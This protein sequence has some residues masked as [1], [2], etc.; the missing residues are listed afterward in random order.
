M[1]NIRGYDFD[2]QNNKDHANSCFFFQ[3]S[4]AKRVPK[5]PFAF[6]SS[7][8]SFDSFVVLSYPEW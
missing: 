3:M 5:G 2:M 7:A 6:L 1:G 8:N 4:E